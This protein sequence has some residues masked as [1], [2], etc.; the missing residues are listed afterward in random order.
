MARATVLSSVL[1]NSWPQNCGKDG[2]HMDPST[3]LASMSRTRWW[4]S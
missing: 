4:M 3:P 2:K 1:L